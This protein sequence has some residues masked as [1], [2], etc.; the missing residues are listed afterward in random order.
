MLLFDLSDIFSR[1]RLRGST[2]LDFLHRMSTG[3]MRGL[4]PGEGKPTVLTTPIGRMVDY[5]MALACEDSVL[6]IGGGGNQDK[7]VRWLRKY[8]FFNDD[9]QVS[10]ETGATRMFGIGAGDDRRLIEKI[11][12]DTSPLALP[13]YA[14]RTVE[15]PLSSD[16]RVTVVRAPQA[17]GLSFFLIGT[18]L[19]P[20]SLIDQ[21]P[22]S[23][24]FDAWRILQGYPRFPNEINEDYI[25]LEAGLWGAV[26]FNKGC[27]TGQEIIARMESRGQIAKKLVWLTGSAE[28]L[29]PGEELLAEG[30]EVVG[31]VTSATHGA[32]LAYVRSTF[33]QENLRLQSR[34]G[35]IV[36]IARIVRI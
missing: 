12:P 24:D 30:G 13:E 33:A 1:I 23:P 16:G 22:I 32:A 19:D 11:S 29:S 34:Q 10:D 3:D 14:H 25:L 5:L 27:Y 31:K 35:A 6:L 7:V 15:S 20:A 36:H 28:T 4:K 21:P 9:V 17:L 18:G 2:R 26:S 8:I